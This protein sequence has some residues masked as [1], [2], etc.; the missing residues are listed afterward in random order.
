M[1]V[2]SII[3]AQMV[4]ARV[5]IST[6]TMGWWDVS[7]ETVSQGMIRKC[8]KGRSATMYRADEMLAADLDC[9][10]QTAAEVD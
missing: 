2:S 3:R 5:Q 4:T 8:N 1:E 9:L 6:S 10:A 7:R